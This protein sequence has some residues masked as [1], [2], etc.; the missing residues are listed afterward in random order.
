MKPILNQDATFISLQ[1]KDAPEI[2]EF[3]NETGIK[4]HHWPHAMQTKDYDDTVAMISQL[5]L[6]I[7]VTQAAIHVAGALGVPCWVLTPKAPM[8]RYGLTGDKMPWY[9]SVKL[10]R[11]KSDWVHVISDVATDLRNWRIEQ[12]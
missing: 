9:K 11:Q 1:Y 7:S 6:V 2:V 3:E 10:Y 4:I 5:D 8:W 12:K